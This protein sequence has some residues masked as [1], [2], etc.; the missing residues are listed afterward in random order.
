MSTSTQ[1]LSDSFNKNASKTLLVIL[2]IILGVRLALLPFPPLVD[3]SDARYAHIAEHMVRTNQWLIPEVHEDNILQAYWSKPPFGFWCMAISMKM[4]GISE[5]SARFPAF[6][7]TLS[8]AFLCIFFLS[9]FIE[10]SYAVLAGIIFVSC[11]FIFVMSGSALVD[12]IFAFFTSA[13]ILLF[14]LVLLQK[15]SYSKIC[16]L[17][18]YTSFALAILT[19]G[20]LGGL[21]VVL[22]VIAFVIFT[23]KYAAIS[24]L[25]PILG[26][27]IIAAIIVP[28][29]IVMER[30]S[31]GFS[32]YFLIEENLN[33]L[34][35]NS[36]N[37]KF[38]SPHRS[39]LGFAGL[40]L[41]V[42][43]LPWILCLKLNGIK[44]FFADSKDK[45]LK[46]FLAC[47]SFAALLPLL[48][49]RHVLVYYLLPLIP[50]LV[51]LLTLYLR[52]YFVESNRTKWLY[53]FFLFLL[54]TISA[55]TLVFETRIHVETFPQISQI[56]LLI[57]GLQ[58]VFVL[59]TKIFNINILSSIAVASVLTTA[60]TS[61]CISEAIGE[62][63]SSSTLFFYLKTEKEI[64]RDSP[65]SFYYE[66]PPSGYFYAEKWFGT[67]QMLDTVMDLNRL[68]QTGVLIV[69]DKHFKEL[70]ETIRSMPFQI[71]GKYRIFEFSARY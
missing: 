40:I 16:L 23:K 15:V 41:P 24:K 27:F 18:A 10:R 59:T 58:V 8:T 36:V 31:P 4:F 14:G 12:P 9:K 38:G 47:F 62:Y 50:G 49:G 39:I 30:Y 53:R 32:R 44:S 21:F 6:L 57:V 46:I 45:E 63:E 51:M 55:G 71:L 25:H 37:L 70:P 11:P 69:R 2:A 48:L 20:P 7:A 35:S 34:T 1:N 13:T 17:V 26:C 68:K 22:P 54:I 60:T 56:I 66:I 42:I 19:K 5:F 64:S 67:E 33:R 43:M 29:F 65:I 61:I 52:D 3:P 28:W